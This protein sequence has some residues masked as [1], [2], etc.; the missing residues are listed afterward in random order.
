M[1]FQGEYWIASTVQELQEVVNQFEEEDGYSSLLVI[2]PRRG[3]EFHK[4]MC[5][6][7]THVKFLNQYNPALEPDDDKHL[8]I[9]PV[10]DPSA[11]NFV[12][13]QWGLVVFVAF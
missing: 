2:D 3:I 7:E 9:H 12:R 8:Y 1:L 13:E 11:M 10:F 6:E 5:R 4:A